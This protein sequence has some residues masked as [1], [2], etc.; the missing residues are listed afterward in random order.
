MARKRGL[1][2]YRSRKKKAKRPRRNATAMV[3]NP[4]IVKDF[5][6]Y[7]VPGFAGY[8]ATRLLARIVYTL[9]QKKFPKLGKH[10]GVVASLAGFG[11]TWWAVHK[12]K[13]LQA[14]H[15]PA[16]VGAGVAALHTAFQT[17]VPKYGWIVSDYRAGQLPAKSAAQLE[18]EANAEADNQMTPE[19][20]AEAMA[21]AMADAAIGDVDLIEQSRSAAPPMPDHRDDP[22]MAA[23]DD[24]SDILGDNSD[25]GAW[26]PN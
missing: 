1:A 6:E 14:Y 20:E 2:A 13:R 21:E 3:A 12:I 18:A 7:I 24:L 9:V 4:P 25:Y 23:E 19:D 22:D 17:Y 5:T 15:T 26:G 8:A 16:V 10:A 11:A